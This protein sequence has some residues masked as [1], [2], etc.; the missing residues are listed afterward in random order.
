M[1]HASTNVLAEG[2]Q[3]D[4]ESVKGFAHTSV[5]F[6]AGIDSNTLVRVQAEVASLNS[7]AIC[8]LHVTTSN[9]TSLGSFGTL[10]SEHA[11][12]LKL[13]L[14]SGSWRPS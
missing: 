12:Y 9:E 2:Y 8:C 11:T 7:I 6:V 1:K 14:C 13:Q 3:R 5:L 4:S 10:R